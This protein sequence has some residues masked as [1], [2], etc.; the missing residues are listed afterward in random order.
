[1]DVIGYI[2]VSTNNQDLQRQRYLINKYCTENGYTLVHIYEDFAISGANLD[3]KE[4][5][6]LLN[7]KK[8]DADLIVISELSRFSRNE[9]YLKTANDI[10]ELLDKA[11]IVL[12]DKPENILTKEDFLDID[13]FIPFIFEAKGSASERKKITTR[14]I[15]GKDTKVA[16]NPLA[17]TE[18][19]YSIPFGFKAVSN[20]NYV[21]GKTPK[22]LLA[23]DDKAMEIV[24]D[25][26]K[27]ISEGMTFQATTDKINM[28]YGDTISKQTSKNI[29]HNTIYKGLRKRKGEY[30]RLPIKQP[31]SDDLWEKANYSCANNRL[32]KGNSTKHFNPIKGIG[33]CICGKNLTVGSIPAKIG[34]LLSYECAERAVLYSKSRC[35][36]PNI[37]FHLL[38]RIVWD[39]VKQNVLSKNYTIKSNEA[40]KALENENKKLQ[41]AIT[42]LDKEKEK[43]DSEKTTIITNGLLSTDS[44]VMKIVDEKVAEYNDKLKDIET[45]ITNIKKEVTKNKKKIT[46]EKKTQTSKELNEMSLEGKSKIFYQMLESIVAYSVKAK[47]GMVIVTFNN[48]LQVIALW[49]RYKKTF[50]W[51]LPVGFQFDIE[52]RMIYVKTMP[53]TEGLDFTISEPET[54]FYEYRDLFKHFDLTKYQVEIPKEELERKD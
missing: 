19:Y 40:I 43:L 9:N 6:N 49:K 37:S 32:F 2:R 24:K 22:S 23:V 10:Y 46:D 36:N 54:K 45:K 16:M 26:F 14:L 5:Q 39:I 11:N 20:P 51:Y 53:K 38:N 7:I 17:I 52:K 13:K 25:V 21:S 12:L 30:F 34:T 15:T 35:K 28:M 4:Y 47:S 31:I 3:R 8:E 1:M 29:I 27:Y 48:G 50:V 18:S 41:D 33:K 42:T 44:S